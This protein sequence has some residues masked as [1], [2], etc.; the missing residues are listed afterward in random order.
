[1]VEEDCSAA[2]VK[3]A[4]SKSKAVKGGNS[5]GRGVDNVLDSLPRECK[6]HG[7]CA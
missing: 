4:A 7:G 5:A 2:S 1:M 6:R 3:W